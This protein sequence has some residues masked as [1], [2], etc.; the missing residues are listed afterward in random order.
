MQLLSQ[1]TGRPPQEVLPSNRGPQ[2]GTRSLQAERSMNLSRF[3]SLQCLRN[4]PFSFPPPS[5]GGRRWAAGGAA[6]AQPAP[7]AHCGP[8]RG[9]P[10]S[11]AGLGGGRLGYTAQAP[12]H[13]RLPSRRRVLLPC[14][15]HL[16]YTSVDPSLCRR[17]RLT[18][19]AHLTP[20]PW[21]RIARGR[22]RQLEFVSLPCG[23][24][25]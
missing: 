18:C 23:R 6:S 21:E 5:L 24:L 9:V 14:Q 8:G 19:Q 22:G 12:A 25:I 2:M 15:V 11:S 4:M 1:G 20:L 16:W 7:A 17:V 13:P 3:L 10:L